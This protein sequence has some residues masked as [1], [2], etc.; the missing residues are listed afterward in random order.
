MKKALGI[1]LVLASFLFLVPATANA[2]SWQT[3]E[4][5]NNS[6]ND[7]LS[8]DTIEIWNDTVNG[9]S[10]PDPAYF[11]VTI[12]S[13]NS[14]ITEDEDLI[15]DATITNTGDNKGTQTVDASH[16]QT[17]QL[18]DA[19][20]VTLSGGSSTTETFTIP[21]SEITSDVNF[22]VNEGDS[23]TITSE[24]QGLVS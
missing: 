17:A 15:I 3:I 6:L 19:R 10:T 2:Y 21:S 24:Y 13:T 14:P 7:D 16:D 18:Y 9:E 11:E 22:T 8:W 4:T 20:D 5:W 23:Y 1:V 12:D